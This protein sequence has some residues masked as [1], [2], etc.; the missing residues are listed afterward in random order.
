MEVDGDI[1]ASDTLNL[2]STQES[3]EP[4]QD[5]KAAGP[6]TL[7]PD[8]VAESQEDALSASC[9]VELPKLSEDDLIDYHPIVGGW[10]VADREADQ[11]VQVVEIIGEYTFHGTRF[12][13]A[14]YGDELIRRVRHQ[15][16]ISR[17]HGLIR[18]C[19]QKED[20]EFRTRF[21]ELYEDYG[22]LRFFDCAC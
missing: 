17:A 5:A 16:F 8:E 14:V 11:A 2:F 12:L 21:P 1:N 13:F 18:V 19:L 10:E 15:V 3:P 9:Y 4:F 22:E 6:S 20:W 7:A